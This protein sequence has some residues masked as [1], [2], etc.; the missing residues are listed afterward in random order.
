[1]HFSMKYY[2]KNNNSY[3]IKHTRHF[4]HESSIRMSHQKNKN[5]NKNNKD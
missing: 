3:I 5:K 4:V 1:M 2:L